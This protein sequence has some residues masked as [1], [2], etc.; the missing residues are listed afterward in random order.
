MAVVTTYTKSGSPKSTEVLVSTAAPLGDTVTL[1]DIPITGL[2]HVFVG[3][4][5][6]DVAGTQIVDS[7]GTF[8]VTMQT[9]NTSNQYESPLDNVIDATT[10]HTVD[11]GANIVGIKVVPSSLSDTVTY[12]VVASFNRN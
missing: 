6:Y 5:M 8:T 7:A 3:V 1:S 4:K 10:P 12:K 2:T 9:I 11:A